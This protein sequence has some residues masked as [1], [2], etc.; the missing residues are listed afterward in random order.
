MDFS[1]YVDLFELKLTVAGN[2]FHQKK[3]TDIQF[4]SRFHAFVLNNRWYNQPIQLPEMEGLKFQ[5]DFDF[6]FNLPTCLFG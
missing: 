2:P 4:G 6:D 5:P 1:V 3:D